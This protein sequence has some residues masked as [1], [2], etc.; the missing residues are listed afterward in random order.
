MAD[1]NGQTVSGR[2]FQSCGD[3]AC[4][5]C[6]L[7][8]CVIL[9]MI[10]CWCSDVCVV[11]IHVCGCGMCCLPVFVCFFFCFLRSLGGGLDA[12]VCVFWC[13]CVCVCV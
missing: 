6:G 12:C 7:W 9:C 10:V 5:L 4:M 1:H 8:Q 13:V 2:V 3:G 11:D